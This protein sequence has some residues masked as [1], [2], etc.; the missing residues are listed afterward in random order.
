MGRSLVVIGLACGC[1]RISFTPVDDAAGS[2]DATSTTTCQQW[3]VFAGTAA[4]PNVN[5]N[6]ENESDPF[7]ADDGLELLLASNR[8][9]SVGLRDIWR[10]TRSDPTQQFSAAQAIAE[11]NTTGDE[12]GPSLTADG[13]TLFFDRDSDLYLATRPDRAAPFGTAVA[14]GELNTS[15]RERAGSITPNGL[16][17]YFESA[18]GATIDIYV[19]ERASASAVFSP[20]VL[21]APVNSSGWEDHPSATPDE[22]AIV[23]ASD[24][25]GGA[26]GFDLYLARRSDV[27]APFDAPVAIAALNSA[28]DELGPFLT[29]DHGALL[30]SAEAGGHTDVFVA[31]RACLAP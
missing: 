13:L 29:R 14:I 20:P 18:R 12:G 25:T 31:S 19:A 30:F 26:G 3:G 4:V 23:F 5:D 24:R 9:P 2:A 8:T 1:G 22:R 15:F 7:L 27:A 28:G 6:N 11:L 16:R 10:A 17:V 21:V